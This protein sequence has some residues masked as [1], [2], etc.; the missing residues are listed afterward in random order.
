VATSFGGEGSRRGVVAR[1][2]VIVIVDAGVAIARA[3]VTVVVGAVDIVGSEVDCIA[4]D[5]TAGACGVGTISRSTG[6]SPW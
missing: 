3:S 1:V 2:I 4:A 5:D 6:R